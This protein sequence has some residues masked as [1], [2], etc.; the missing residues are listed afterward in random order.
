MT[1]DTTSFYDKFQTSNSGSPLSAWFLHNCSNAWSRC[2]GDHLP[3]CFR[4][5]TARAANAAFHP[6]NSWEACYHGA[7]TT[8]HLLQVTRGKEEK[9][10]TLRNNCSVPS[11]F[12]TKC[13]S[14]NFL[15]TL[16]CQ[17]HPKNSSEKI[18]QWNITATCSLN[19]WND[20]K[21]WRSSIHNLLVCLQKLGHQSSWAVYPRFV[22][23]I[24]VCSLEQL[25]N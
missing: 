25:C 17:L 2:E 11:S 7:W 10:Q 5:N 21:N 12:G 9:S 19:D 15:F 6:G 18:L 23:N 13:C 22:S 14:F 1:S 4:D 20:C 3:G 8:C 16:P 24:E